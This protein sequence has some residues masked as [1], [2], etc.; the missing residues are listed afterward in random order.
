MAKVTFSKLGLKKQNKIET[1]NINGVDIEVKQYLP[2]DEKL[3]IIEKVLKES[4]DE[5]NFANPIKMEVFL[6]LE[7]M[8]NYTNIGFT[9]AQKK[10]PVKLY[11]LLE[12]NGVIVEVIS[13]IPEK[14]YNYLIDSATEIIENFYKYRNSAYGIMENISKDY[15]D[16]DFDATEI[17]K[18]IGNRENVE[19]LQEVMNKLG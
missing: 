4:A 1:V 6:D 13:A 18:K 14:E 16:L 8:Y 10:D 9:D 17:Q 19:F 3:G 5:N 2:V 15:K 11:D 7:I 12:E